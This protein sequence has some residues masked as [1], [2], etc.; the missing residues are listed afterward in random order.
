MTRINTNVTSLTAQHNLYNNEASLQTSLERLSTGLRINSGKDDPSGLIASSVLGSEVVTVGQAITNSQRANNIVATADAALSQVGTLLNNIAGLVQASANKGAISASEIAANQVQVDSAIESIDRIGQTTVFGGDQLLNGNKA[1]NVTGALGSA[2]LSTSDIQVNSFDPSLHTASPND[3][4]TVKIAQT[5]AQ[6][7]VNIV[8]DSQVAGGA[9]SLANLSLDTGTTRAS[10]TLVTNNF[11]VGSTNS[12]NALSTTSTRATQK[13]TGAAIQA[14]GGSATDTLTLHVTGNTGSADITVKVGGATGIATDDNNLISAINAQSANTGVIA[15]GAGGNGDITLTSSNVGAAATV[16]VTATAGTYAGTNSTLSFDA[17][18][19]SALAGVGAGTLSFNVNGV[20]SS[21]NAKTVNVVVD[22]SQVKTAATFASVVGGLVTAGG[23]AAGITSSGS[24]VT[25]TASQASA[26]AITITGV[27]GKVAGDVTA[28]TT[29]LGSAASANG[30]AAGQTAFNA[31]VGTLAAGTNASFSTRKITQATLAAVTADTSSTVSLTIAGTGSTTLNGKSLQGA[32]GI[33]TAT[34]LATLINAN[35]GTTGVSAA[36]DSSGNVILSSTTAGSGGLANVTFSNYSGSQSTSVV[37]TSNLNTLS[38]SGAATLTFTVTGS[39]GNHAFSLDASTVAALGAQYLATQINGQTG[40]TGVT[41]SINNSGDL[42]LTNN[43]DGAQSPAFVSA[44]G[45]A[46]NSVAVFGADINQSQVTGTAANDVPTVAA[47]NG[48]VGT[49]TAGS[50]AAPDSTVFTI[51][52]NKGS[53]TVSTAQLAGGNDAV[54]NNNGGNSG[55]T[56]LTSLINARTGT[57]GITASVNSSGNVV[58]TSDG[59]GSSSVASVTATGGGSDSTIVSAGHAAST[60]AGTDGNSNT[61]TLQLV[62]DLGRAVI[63]VD[64]NAVINNSS[65][66]TNAINAVTAQTG[67]TASGSGTGANVTLTSQH[68]GL[69]AVVS[70]SAIAATNASDISLYNAGGTQQSAAGIDVAGTVTTNKGSGAFTGQGAN[71]TYTDSSLNFTAASSPGLAAPTAATTTLVGTGAAGAGV[72]HLTAGASNA[73]TISF[74]VT[75]SLG[76]ATISNVNV[77]AFQG[78][79]RVL[80]DAINKVSQQTGVVASTQ[81][82]S[83]S[84]AL[85]NITLASSTAGTSG[86]VSIQATAATAAADVTTFNNAASFTGTA[87]GTNAPSTAVANFDV[88]GGALFQI[89][90][91]VSFANQVNVNIQT[92]DTNLLGR[93]VG[94]TGSLSLHDLHTGGSQQ[95]SSTDLSNAATI[96]AQAISQVAT[97]RGQLGA[98][99]A[100]VLQSNITS[101][102]TALEQITSAQSSIQDTD[103]AAET[104]NLTRAQVLVQ[105]GTSVLAIANQQPQSV[106]SLLPRQ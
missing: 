36:L 25:F 82:S 48:A 1:F 41:A 23:L 99:Q 49:L 2:F 103:F 68:Y 39:V 104:A 30:V 100:N 35:T 59:A 9:T 63:T 27:R 58:L 51:T 46:G 64:N 11:V 98:L 29:A 44:V 34:N 86:S 66:L 26:T 45:G 76:T 3:D 97:L 28:V 12:L 17:T 67:V 18:G 94:T 53:A 57:T 83:G 19:F 70:L 43:A 20:D 61:V 79:S 78:D 85:A 16:G 93:N 89:G 60:Q 96:V 71:I 74:T 37:S 5:A 106:L 101:Q 84:Y 88:T 56:A 14:L 13:I 77:A 52:G 10:T 69:A 8:G 31:A 87:A 40:A 15:T 73:N 32:T 21:G 105:A 75:G 102:Q 47:L 91:Q 92:L 38:G 95:L 62:G 50:N 65:A 54:I 80:A 42:L 72:N 6:K 55:A 33:D 81:A 7:T 22:A 90:P 4:V 24:T